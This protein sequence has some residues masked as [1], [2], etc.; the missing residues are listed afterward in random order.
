MTTATEAQK[1][2]LAE[3]FLRLAREA[4]RGVPSDLEAAENFG[5]ALFECPDGFADVAGLLVTLC[6]P[7][8]LPD[9][10]RVLA[11]FEAVR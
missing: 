1:M 2:Q 11:D 5:R 7:D 3:A 9:I 4:L 10:L 6:R 8:E